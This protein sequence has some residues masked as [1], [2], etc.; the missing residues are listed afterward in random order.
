MYRP[1]PLPAGFLDRP[2]AHRGLHQATAGLLENT[3]AAFEAAI[4]RGFG[5]ECDIQLT[6]DGEAAVFHDFTL[7][8]LTTASGRVDS[9]PLAALTAIPFRQGHH[10]I[11]PLSALLTLVAGRVPLVVEVKSRFNGDER[12]TRAAVAA[13]AG[14][15][16]PLVLKSFD[17]GVLIA[18]RKAGATV[19][20]GIV[21]MQSYEDPEAGLDEAGRHR[22]GNLLHL[23]ESQPDFISWH[24]ASIPCAA[25]F[26]C[27]AGLGLPV[28]S[29][30]VRDA[31]TA[32]RIRPHVD[33]IVFEGFLPQ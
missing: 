12:L 32:A 15:P 9:Q 22:L 7:D 33:Q 20:L 14:Y 26:L 23:M 3:R 10:G 17:P 13:I 31:A 5:I 4:A 21:A 16:G 25:P 27:R 19:P 6:A 2:I 28:M 11:E 29:W 8:R 18:A 30:T 1:R 24:Q